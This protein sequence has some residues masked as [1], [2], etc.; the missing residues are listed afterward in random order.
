M[1]MLFLVYVSISGYYFTKFFINTKSRGYYTLRDYYE[2]VNSANWYA[3][4]SHRKRI[5]ICI[6]AK[7]VKHHVDISTRTNETVI[8]CI[9]YVY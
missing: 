1:F 6:C 8:S 4:F 7:R 9:K 5:N 3:S 2:Y